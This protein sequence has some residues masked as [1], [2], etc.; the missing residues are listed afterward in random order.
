MKLLI[1]NARRDER[2]VSRIRA[3]WSNLNLMFVPGSR[4][5]FAAAQQK[6]AAGIAA[7]GVAIDE[8]ETMG[9]STAFFRCLAETY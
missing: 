8:G 1:G 9:R 5:P 6:D 2:E 7:T 3:S 4:R